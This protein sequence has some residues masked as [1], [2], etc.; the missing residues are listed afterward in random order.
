V[1]DERR[2][3]KKSGVVAAVALVFLI[4][5]FTIVIKS[6]SFKKI[7]KAGPAMMSVKAVL[8][9]NL[10]VLV[11]DIENAFNPWADLARASTGSTF[12]NRFSIQSKWRDF[13]L[14][15]NGD[16]S[17]SVFPSDETIALNRGADRLILSYISIPANLRQND[18]Y[19]YE[20]TGEK[21]WDSEYSYKNA[22]AKFRCAFIIHVEPVGESGTRVEIFEFQPEV[23]VGEKLA[24]SAHSV[25]P[26]LLHD[27]RS[28]QT[29]TGD[30]LEILKLIQDAAGVPS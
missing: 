24:W 11:S 1:N 7:E 6:G 5:C 23:W 18:F 12:K 29:T 2:D 17:Y 15:R 30:R 8:P 4:A 14:F 10:T 9:L 20:P 13:Y 27:I 3:T 19:L 26:V 16:S 25:F 28:V 22:P 21:Y